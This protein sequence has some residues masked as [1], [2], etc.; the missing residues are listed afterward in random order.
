MHKP[1]A[2]VPQAG[3][4]GPSQ[5][6]QVLQESPLHAALSVPFS[7]LHPC[8]EPPLNVSQGTSFLGDKVK[9]KEKKKIQDPE[10]CGI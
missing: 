2:K 1:Q 8:P 3:L 4:R 7:I 6:E 9:L 10:A 5:K